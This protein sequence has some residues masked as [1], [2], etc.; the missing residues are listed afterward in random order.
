MPQ[1]RIVGKRP[2]LCRTGKTR[3]AK[4]TI[5]KGTKGAKRKI[6]GLKKQMKPKPI[7]IKDD[8]IDEHN[9]CEEG[10]GKGCDN[11]DVDR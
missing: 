4:R 5:W 8:E 7:G 11:D 6:Q 3:K 9:S 10:K 1:T 2:A